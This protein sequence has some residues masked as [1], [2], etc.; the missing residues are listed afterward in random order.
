MRRSVC[1]EDIC[2]P[3]SRIPET[4]EEIQAISATYSIPIATY[5]HI[6]G[7]GLHPGHPIDGRNAD[8]IRR[9]LQCR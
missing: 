4:L 5:G 6:G 2:V 8:E 9:V 3:V 7:G 1:G